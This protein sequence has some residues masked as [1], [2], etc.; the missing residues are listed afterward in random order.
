[1]SA[2]NR[3]HGECL[4]TI[5]NQIIKAAETCNGGMGPVHAARLMSKEDHAYIV[6]KLGKVAETSSIP[7]V[8]YTCCLCH[9]AV[10]LLISP[11]GTHV[12]TYNVAGLMMNR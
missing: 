2:Q 1:M 5:G 3:M 12:D 6:K 4:L 10:A 9:W 7:P 11:E 8:A